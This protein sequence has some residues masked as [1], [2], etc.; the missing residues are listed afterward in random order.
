MGKKSATGT[1]ELKS[2]GLVKS[3]P[4]Q[5]TTYT[6]EYLNYLGDMGVVNIL[7][8][9]WVFMESIGAKLI[10]F[11]LLYSESQNPLQ[12]ND[13]KIKI[14]PQI[15]SIIK[16]LIREKDPLIEIKMVRYLFIFYFM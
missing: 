1:K 4:Y 16:V 15:I 14:P 9:M 3:D 12:F 11:R 2:K 5:G 8:N 13:F 7:Q 6:K 10:G